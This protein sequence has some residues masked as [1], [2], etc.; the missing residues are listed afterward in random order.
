MTFFKNFNNQKAE[1]RHRSMEAFNLDSSDWA[2]WSIAVWGTDLSC[3]TLKIATNSGHHSRSWNSGQIHDTASN[4]H[5]EWGTFV[6]VASAVGRN[7]GLDCA[8]LTV[9]NLAAHFAEQVGLVN[10]MSLFPMSTYSAHQQF[11]PKAKA[12]ARW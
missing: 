8:A 12:G 11:Y 9:D 10:S 6:D 3:E 5:F 7:F 2:E 4:H 1:S